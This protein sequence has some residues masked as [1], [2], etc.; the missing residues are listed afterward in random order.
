MESRNININEKSLNIKHFY[1]FRKLKIN[2]KNI[3]MI[4]DIKTKTLFEH[5]FTDNN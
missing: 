2:Y 5:S 4:I 1:V 3:R